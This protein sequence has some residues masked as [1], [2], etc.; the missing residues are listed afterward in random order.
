MSAM[1][2]QEK[3]GLA[4]DHELELGDDLRREQRLVWKEAVVVLLVLA[5]AAI[6][7]FLV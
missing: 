5:V 1:E 6:R 7:I 2:P 3:V 4:W